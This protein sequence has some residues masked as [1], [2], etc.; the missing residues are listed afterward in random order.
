[1]WSAMMSA[2]VI[3]ASDYNDVHPGAP[4]KP[5][6]KVKLGAQQHRAKKSNYH[7]PREIEKILSGE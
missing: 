4:W 2:M 7:D 3:P 5:W 6:A 1:V